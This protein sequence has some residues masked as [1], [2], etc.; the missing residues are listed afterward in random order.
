MSDLDTRLANL[1]PDKLELL[2]ARLRAEPK[3]EEAPPPTVEVPPPTIEPRPEER[4]EPFP[5]TEIQEAYWAGRSGLFD[6]GS[7]GANSYMEYQFRGVGNLFLDRLEWAFQSFVERHDMM[8]TILLPDG[9]QQVLREVPPFR[10]QRVDLTGRSP[11]EVEEEIQR[12]RDRMCW[13]SF[14]IDRWPLFEVI[15]QLQDNFRM[16]LHLRFD[17]APLD[18]LEVADGCG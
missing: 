10:I 15:A 17:A 11:E 4:Y 14:A 13:E 3:S 2:R 9:R 6:L 18:D 8:R 1:S 16:R 12:V 5:L 7:G